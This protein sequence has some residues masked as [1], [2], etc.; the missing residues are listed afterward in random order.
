MTPEDYIA[1]LAGQI[2]THRGLLPKQAVRLAVET[3][4]EVQLA[5]QLENDQK[6]EEHRVE[7]AC[8]HCR[9][10]GQLH[11]GPHVFDCPKCD[12][13]GKVTIARPPRRP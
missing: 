4:K 3:L 13:K 11:G 1:N 9:G 8:D 2:V 10:E 6:E 5:V 12:G 7:T